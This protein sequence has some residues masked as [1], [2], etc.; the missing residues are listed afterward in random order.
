VYVQDEIKA[1]DFVFSPGLRL[2]RYDGLVSKTGPQPRLGIA[3]N[4]KKTGTV[5]SPFQK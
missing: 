2:D 5:R 1:G 4:L 3:Y